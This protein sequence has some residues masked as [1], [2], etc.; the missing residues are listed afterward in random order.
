M[1][2]D[3]YRYYCLDSTGMIHSAEWF[4]AAS[5]QEAIIHVETMHKDATC[6]VWQGSRLVG[7]I[8]PERMSA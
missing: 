5:D 4:E 8:V 1:S 6:E 2:P 3:S 7:K